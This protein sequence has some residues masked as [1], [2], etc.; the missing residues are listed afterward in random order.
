MWVDLVAVLQWQVWWHLTESIINL[1]IMNKPII[2]FLVA[3]AVSLTAFL[4]V[5][6]ILTTDSYN[7]MWVETI[8]FFGVSFWCMKKFSSEYGLSEASVFCAVVLGRIILEIP[9]KI[10]LWSGTYASLIYLIG[11]VLAIVLGTICYH[12]KKS[13]V[14]LISFI[15]LTLF[16][17]FVLP[18]WDS[19]LVKP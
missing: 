18:V 13:G 7:A 8:A 12:Y 9:A 3:T 1:T 10:F 6:W 5:A 15:A 11:S 19:S 2:K 4:C 14:F 16:N 17:T